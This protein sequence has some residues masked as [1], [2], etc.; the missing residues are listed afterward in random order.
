MTL[1]AVW[2]EPSP[3]DRLWC[4]GDTRLSSTGYGSL[5]DNAPKL[6][7]LSVGWTIG[8]TTSFDPVHHWQ[9]GFAYAGSSTAALSAHGFASIALGHLR[10][11]GEQCAP[12]MADI[13]HWLAR[14]AER[15]MREVGSPFD[16][17]LFGLCPAERRYR[18]L[19]LRASVADGKLTLQ[20]SEPSVEHSSEV[21]VV[22]S[23]GPLFLER[24]AEVQAGN[25]PHTP[26]HRV[27][28]ATLDILLRERA[29][30]D[31]GGD[32][33]IAYVAGAVF[34]VLQNVAPI[35]RGEPS[36][37]I[38]LLGV[39]LDELGGVGPFRVSPPGL[40]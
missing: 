12:N 18:A 40:A 10:L 14:V 37:R 33:Q 32:V 5:T 17:I 26:A 27:P 20:R 13:N 31:I 39:D 29:A 7:R 19:T 11:W 36:A 4:A 22:G 3:D 38:T 15:Y 28:R 9:L 25:V 23:G 8:N 30:P 21:V 24:L 35:V 6:L 2:Y 34:R 1:V 16:Y